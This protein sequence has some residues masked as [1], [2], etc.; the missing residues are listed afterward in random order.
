M[1][2]LP[3]SLA[4][5]EKAFSVAVPK[6]ELS[7]NWEAFQLG[8]E[9]V[10][11][12][13]L[14]KETTED[15]SQVEKSVALSAYT[16]Q[17]KDRIIRLWKAHTEVLKFHFPNIPVTHLARYVHDLLVFDQGANYAAFL[18]DAL[19]LK[20]KYSTDAEIALRTLARTYFIKDEIFVSHQMISPMKKEADKAFY[21]NLGKSFDV[22]HINRPSFDVAGRKIEFDFSPRPWMLKLMR[23]MRFL[24]LTLKDW[25]KREKE[26]SSNIRRELLQGA[27]SIRVRELDSV[28]GYREV[29]YKSA[30]RYRV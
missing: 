10:I 17:R 12:G 25:H 22:V 9:W 2:R 29:R 20:Q 13:S 27:T 18:E 16:W 24:R 30:E 1:G 23:H 19:V 15:L 14:P 26:I 6:A 11:S 21:K 4:D 5:M 28:K 8:R 7:L 3:F